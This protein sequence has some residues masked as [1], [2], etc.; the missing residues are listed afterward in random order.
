MWIT[1]DNTAIQAFEGIAKAALDAR[2]PLIINDPEFT[3]RGALACVGL[4]WYEAG[5]A[6]SKLS[7]RVLLGERPRNLPVEEVAVKRIVLNQGMARKLGVKFP[8]ALLREA[9]R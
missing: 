9:N 5:L 3:E 1:G 8:D 7:A 6:A 4:G 2:L